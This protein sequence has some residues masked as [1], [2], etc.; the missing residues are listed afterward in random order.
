MS[1]AG[2]ENLRP[3]PLERTWSPPAAGD[4][5]WADGSHDSSGLT[6]KFRVLNNFRGVGLR[7]GLDATWI[8]LLPAWSV[9]YFARTV[10]EAPRSWRCQQWNEELWHFEC[11][12]AVLLDEHWECSDFLVGGLKATVLV[13]AWEQAAVERVWSSIKPL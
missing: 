2:L 13:S 11:A 6:R 12:G 5:L 4:Q 1:F 10:L 3:K 7:H 8:D 9:D